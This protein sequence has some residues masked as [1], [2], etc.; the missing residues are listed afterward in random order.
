MINR[1]TSFCTY[2]G[3]FIDFEAPQIDDLVFYDL[4]LGISRI[5][6]FAGQAKRNYTVAHHSLLVSLLCPNEFKVEGLIHDLSEGILGDIVKPLKD[7]LP[8]YRDIEK[9]WEL[10]ILY[11][12]ANRPALPPE[13]KKAD[14]L[15]YEIERSVFRFA[16]PTSRPI[17]LVIPVGVRIFDFFD[18][19]KD[20]EDLGNDDGV[21]TAYLH[22]A[23]KLGIDIN[24]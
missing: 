2:S 15:A 14:E 17:N 10:A 23:K 5:P 24:K 3:S 16:E 19:I 13:V 9:R 22:T 8:D 4:A 20:I 11:K 1:D 18:Q 12:Y 21:L 7:L 6:R